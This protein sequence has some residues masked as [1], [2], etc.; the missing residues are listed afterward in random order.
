MLAIGPKVCRFKPG[1]GW[2]IFKGNKNLKHTFLQRESKS[3]SPHVIRFYSMSNIAIVYDR[4][5]TLGK[6]KDISCQLPASL[7][8]VSAAT[9]ATVD[10]SGMIRIQMEMHNC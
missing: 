2:W 7:L 10:E 5:T 8:G 3:I 6:L 9:R 1:S 4:D